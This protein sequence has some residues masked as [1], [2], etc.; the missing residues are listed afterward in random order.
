MSIFTNIVIYS[1]QQNRPLSFT[2]SKQE[3]I[4]YHVKNYNDVLLGR[5]GNNNK[6]SGNEQLRIFARSDARQYSRSGKLH[7]SKLSRTLVTRVRQ[8]DPPGRFLKQNQNTKEWVDV[9]D[10][11]AREKTSQVLRDAASALPP[12]YL[13]CDARSS[14]S[15]KANCTRS[16]SQTVKDPR[17]RKRA[18]NQIS[19]KPYYAEQLCQNGNTSIIAAGSA[20]VLNKKNDINPSLPAQGHKRQKGSYYT[21][22]LCQNGNTSIIATINATVLKTNNINP[23]LLASGHNRL[24]RC[25][26][27]RLFLS[28]YHQK[29]QREDSAS[30]FIEWTYSP[31]RSSSRFSS[32]KLNPKLKE[33]PFDGTQYLKTN[34]SSSIGDSNYND[35]DSPHHWLPCVESFDDISR[36]GDT[37]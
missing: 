30:P 6:Y 32:P 9:G 10:I 12:D 24:K 21:E 20:T 34:A 31:T 37:S 17:P 35:L 3:I 13:L 11:T 19:T 25:T 8:L 2:S 22:H 28:D 1:Y 16:P 27:S 29:K 26:T 15:Q 4:E 33:S 5:G 14:L 36:W 7:K 18:D 23:S